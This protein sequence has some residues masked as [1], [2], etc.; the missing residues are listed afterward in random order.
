[1]KACHPKRFVLGLLPSLLLIF[2]L[3]CDSGT[4]LAGGGIDGS[5]IISVG[6]IS[7]FGSIV[8]NGTEFDTSEAAI[9]VGG[10]VIGVGDDVVLDNLDVGRVVTVEGKISEDGDSFM[11]DRVIYYNNVKGPVE[12][13]LYPDPTIIRIVVMG[14]AVNVNAVTEIKGTTFDSLA[15]NDL[16]EVSGFFDDEG[17]IW[18]T[19]LEKIEFTS[20]LIVEVKGFVA[21]LDTNLKIFDINE[22]IVDYS[23]ADTSGLPGGEPV[24][25]L[26]VEAEGT[27]DPDNGVMQARKIELA[28][29]IEVEDADEIEITGF[30]TDFVSIFEFTVGTQVVQTDADTEYIDWPEDGIGPGDK[31]EAE[32][33]LIDGILFAHE[34]EFWKPDQIEVEDF[35]TDDTLAPDEFTVGDQVVQT[36]ADTVFEPEDLIIVEG[37]KVEVKGVPVDINRS[38]LIADKVSLEED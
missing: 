7:A 4:T 19:Y 38:I 26:F 14:Q 2:C 31:L 36:N 22:L 24:E 13:I 16:V 28:D 11:A 33:T 17:I 35:V 5:G 9:I 30:V 1:M 18:A 32:G 29:E 27:Y 10:E 25:G 23:L 20:D 37:I 6:S 34:I 8:V 3:N 15:L 21:N 12:S